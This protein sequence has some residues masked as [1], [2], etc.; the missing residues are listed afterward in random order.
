M[1]TIRQTILLFILILSFLSC[2]SKTRDLQ[3]G[4]LIFQDLDCGEICDAIEKITPGYKG[5]KFSHVAIVAKKKGGEWWLIEAY[6]PEVK[7]IKLDD[8]LKRSLDANGRSNVMLG[9]MKKEYRA[10]AKAAVGYA[11]E[12]I[13]KKYDAVFLI[14][15]DTYYCA[16]LVYEVFKKANQGIP[17]FKLNPM[18]FKDPQTKKIIPVWEKYYQKLKQ[19]VPE[20][21]PGI[22]P[23][24]ISVSSKLTMSAR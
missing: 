5:R 24:S 9:R 13:G 19:P 17:F 20:G 18:T 15:N 12:Y 6:P 10:I 1:K 7:F 4:D 2:E 14:D 8:F 23:G 22:N 16:E 11:K 3:V 21:R